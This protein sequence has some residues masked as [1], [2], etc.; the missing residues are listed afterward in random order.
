MCV[1]CIAV[2]NP[3]F[4]GPCWEQFHFMISASSIQRRQ[5]RASGG[6][7]VWHN[8]HLAA[9]LRSSPVCVCACACAHLDG[10]FRTWL[11][12]FL[13][14]VVQVLGFCDDKTQNVWDWVLF[15]CSFFFFSG[16]WCCATVNS[17]DRYWTVPIHAVVESTPH[18]YYIML[19]PARFHFV[20]RRP[21]T[22]CSVLLRYGLKTSFENIKSIVI[23][24]LEWPDNLRNIY[25]SDRQSDNI[26]PPWKVIPTA[27]QSLDETN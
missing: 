19:C 3:Y 14:S 26:R 1:S 10:T 15:D 9:R 8:N 18:G 24:H 22:L 21:R 17:H 16:I 2:Y 11:E 20:S 27:I 4:L 7:R 13:L 6:K 5:R 25:L 12:E 23:D